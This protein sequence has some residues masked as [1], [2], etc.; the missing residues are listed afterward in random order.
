MTIR[1]LIDE[2]QHLAED[3]GDHHTVYV[4]CDRGKKPPL[5]VAAW[6]ADWDGHEVT[7]K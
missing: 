1:D 4:Q 5:R 7:I 6:T 2:L 3:V